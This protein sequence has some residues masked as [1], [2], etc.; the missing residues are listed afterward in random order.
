MSEK[1]S[2]W[3][4]EGLAVAGLIALGYTWG[5]SNTAVHAAVPG[6]VQFQ[7]AP[8]NGDGALSVYDPGSRSISVYRSATSGNPRLQCSYRFVVR[9]NGEIDRENCPIPTLR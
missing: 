4:R 9:P 3:V 7:L 5:H 1:V 6:D 8:F 2:R